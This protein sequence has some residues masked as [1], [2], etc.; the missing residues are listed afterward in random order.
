[1]S[2][3]RDPIKT[4]ILYPRL[5]DLTPQEKIKLIVKM[6]PTRLTNGSRVSRRRSKPHHYR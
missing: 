5:P 3:Q 1:M 6:L 4:G 2:P